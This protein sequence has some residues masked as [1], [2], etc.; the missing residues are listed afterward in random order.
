MDYTDELI[1]KMNDWLDFIEVLENNDDKRIKEKTDDYI[2]YQKHFIAS[3]KI[4]SVMR[5]IYEETG[6]DDAPEIDKQIVNYIKWANKIGMQEYDNRV[7]QLIVLAI[8]SLIIAGAF[9]ENQSQQMRL[10]KQ[11]KSLKRLIE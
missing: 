10:V 11:A 4:E 3:H 1:M 5:Q 7:N 8:K 9:A 2:N 6:K